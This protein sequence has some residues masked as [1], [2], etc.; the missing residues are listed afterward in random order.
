MRKFGT[1]A[2]EFFCF[3]MEGSDAV[4]KIPLATSMPV[5]IIKH[6][7]EGF[8]GQLFILTQYMGEDAEKI[9]AGEMADIFRA[10]NDAGKEQGASA[11]E[12]SA[13]SES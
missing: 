7:K 3:Q 2:P 1:D 5:G 11:G 6:L 12:S 8:D 13:S 4:Y 9:T 10:W